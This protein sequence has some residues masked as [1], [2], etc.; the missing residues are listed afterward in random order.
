MRPATSTLKTLL[1]GWGPQSTIAV[2][3]LYTITLST[4]EVFRYS[5]FQT[6]V[7]A[8]AP[9]TTSPTFAYLIGPR[10]RRAKTSIH[11][12]VEVSEMIV[13]VLVGEKD[14]L[15]IN[16]QSITWQKAAWAGLFDGAYVELQR[17]FIQMPSLRVAGTI[18]WFY[19]RVAEVEVQR[20]KITIHVKSLL[21]LLTVQ[22]PKRLYQSS[23]TFV[24]GDAM[25]GFDREAR[26]TDIVSASGTT[27]NEIHCGLTPSPTTLY[28][29]G[30]VIGT[31]GANNGFSRGI[32]AMISGVIYFLKPW[33]FPVAIG[34]TF[35]L[36]PGCDHTLAGGCT[37]FYGSDAPNHFGGFPYIPPPEN[38][39]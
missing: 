22:M 4:G 28:N 19:G 38:A 24:F 25:C 11:L 10:F 35:H 1:D 8:P 36:L 14:M 15:G 2:A 27:Q 13:D 18:T 34:D 33:I 3:D 9:N 37:T 12:G 6:R 20:S 26:S 17:A 32:R 21:D 7:D 30:T 29:N 39:V 16:A 23:C 31:S 5:G